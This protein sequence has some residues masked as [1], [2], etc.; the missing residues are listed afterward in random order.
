MHRCAGLPVKTWLLS[1]YYTFYK[2]AS[3]YWGISEK[4]TH[5]KYLVDTTLIQIA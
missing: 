5:W 3:E 1:K 2:L 4:T